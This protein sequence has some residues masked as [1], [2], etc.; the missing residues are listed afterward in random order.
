ML[1]RSVFIMVKFKKSKL[2]I[3]ISLRKKLTIICEFC[4]IEPKFVN[5]N[6]I[7]IE[8]TNLEYVE[9][10]RLLVKDKMFLFFNYGNEVYDGD[11]T[12]K[13]L[14]KDLENYIRTLC[15]LFYYVQG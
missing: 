15:P 11:L 5:G 4:K 3:E 12:K 1:E 2:G 10:H 8:H 13:V 7:T 14:I 6:L 9:P